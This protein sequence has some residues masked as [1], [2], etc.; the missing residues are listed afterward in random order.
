MYEKKI[1]ILFS[2]TKLKINFNELWYFKR[3]LTL[4]K[5]FYSKQKNIDKPIL[6]KVPGNGNF[7][8]INR[9]EYLEIN[10]AITNKI[11]KY[12]DDFYYE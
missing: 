7:I 5:K 8:R 6:L 11:T 4:V 10:K 9:Y 12:K 1:E 3:L 2:K